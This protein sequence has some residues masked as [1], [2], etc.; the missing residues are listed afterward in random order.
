MI[1]GFQYFK[2]FIFVA[3]VSTNRSGGGDSGETHPSGT[4][5][6]LPN[7]STTGGMVVFTV[8]L[9]V[10]SSWGFGCF[11]LFLVVDAFRQRANRL[12]GNSQK[13]WEFPE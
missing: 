5:Q 7:T 8:G 6:W 9:V 11:R 1:T 13:V 4:F 12:L 10:T 3:N 2:G